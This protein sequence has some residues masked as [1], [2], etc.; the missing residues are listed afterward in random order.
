FLGGPSLAATEVVS[1][2]IR[3]DARGVDGDR[4]VIPVTFDPGWRAEIDGQA[5]AVEPHRGAF[6][7]VNLPVGSSELRL[8]Y[9]PPEVGLGLAASACAL[10]ITLL[11]LAR[12]GRPSSAGKNDSRAWM[13]SRR[14]VRIESMTTPWSSSP[15][16]H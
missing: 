5:V 7:S 13:A 9:D 12:S 14:R 1:G 11:F 8:R 4:R 3:I 16:S 10:G 2:E 15:A 6:L